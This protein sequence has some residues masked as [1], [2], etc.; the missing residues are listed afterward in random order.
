MNVVRTCRR[1]IFAC[2][3]VSAASIVNSAEA[4]FLVFFNA[5][6]AELTH[7]AQLLVGRALT[8]AKT[9][10]HRIEVI[11]HDDGVLPDRQSLELSQERALTTGQFLAKKGVQKERIFI[12]GVGSNKPLV[13]TPKGVAV[14]QNRFVE[15]RFVPAIGGSIDPTLR[16]LK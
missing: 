11:G 9:Q 7:E 5:G 2:L 10:D 15:I 8:E 6:S 14:A 3:A 1:L 12:G 4:N 13:P 16:P